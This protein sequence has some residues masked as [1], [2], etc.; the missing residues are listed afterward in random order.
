MTKKRIYLLFAIVL[1]PVVV[2][3]AA[4]NLIDLNQFKPV[5]IEKV[6]TLT[7]RDLVI[8]GDIAWQFWPNLGISIN[9]VALSN[10][11]GFA[12]KNLLAL[13]QAQVSVALLPLVSQRIEV[14]S[15]SLVGA[16]F[17]MQSLANGTTNLDG[18]LSPRSLTAQ[19]DES[20]SQQDEPSSA[21]S[22]AMNPDWQLAVTKLSIKDASA[23]VLDEQR[24]TQSDIRDLDLQLNN[25]SL[26]HWSNLQFSLT[27][28][29]NSL[30]FSLA[31]NAELQI[32]D[33]IRQ[34]KM[35]NV[36]LAASVRDE[37]QQLEIEKLRLTSQLLSLAEASDI[38]LDLSGSKQ[39][40][41]FASEGQL[42]VN[43]EPNLSTVNL[44]GVNL[45][46]DISGLP[47]AKPEMKLGLQGEFLLDSQTKTLKAPRLSILLDDTRL[48]G[49]A[50]LALADI[51]AIDLDLHSPAIDLDA[52]FP[53]KQA[54]ANP[55]SATGAHDPQ[56]RAGHAEAL[57]GQEPDLSGLN[58]VNLKAKLQVD[59]LVFNQL[60]S[61]DVVTNLTLQQGKAQL[62]QLRANFYQGSIELAAELDATLSPAH[63]QLRPRI[64]NVSI[65]P[66]LQDIAK[67]P[68]LSG[69]ANISG[70]L[71][72]VG[73]S[74][75][76]LR[77]DLRGNISASLTDGILYGVNLAKM[78]REARAV[79]KGESPSNEQGE[80]QTDFS[81][82]DASLTIANG[83][84]TV[85]KMQLQAPGVRANN[86][87]ST[88]LVTETLDFVLSASVVETSKGQGSQ[89]MADLN[90]ITVPIRIEGT[91]QQPHYTLDIAKL[92]ANNALLKSN[93]D[94]QKD[95]LQQKAEKELNRFFE[96]KPDNDPLKKA[97]ND[98][99]NNLFNR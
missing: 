62:S 81:A 3:T 22:P 42:Q 60:K 47:L 67:Q 86:Q 28:K 4:V 51:P 9:D 40:L 20:K 7:G 63:Y 27:G 61:S 98:L 18:L 59:Q 64:N 65:Q 6:K 39:Q 94:K 78:L 70:N 99:L 29:Q 97:T 26:A 57:S 92:I 11:K 85:N 19:Q 38:A 36:S 88:N 74:P 31:G 71:Q 53:A 5:I 66:L 45:V 25:F 12:E 58:K 75:L 48:D 35:K 79:L 41:R 17:F 90:G 21:T 91:W 32:N 73:L 82:L 46:A 37:T 93:L 54:Q 1:L 8:N 52:W 2:L 77:Q 80:R 96:G 84:A 72:G 24:A 13:E 68:L 83:V 30:N 34:S 44:D 89:D 23:L 56:A 14:N 49:T 43:V 50:Q 33:A 55:T 16:R 87:G 95:K 15:L 10:P 69:R 76:R